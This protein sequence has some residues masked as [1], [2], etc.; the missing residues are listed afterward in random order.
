MRKVS[1]LVVKVSAHC[2]ETASSDLLPKRFFELMH[3]VFSGAK[4][5]L[6]NSYV[7]SSQGCG[8]LETSGNCKFVFFIA[9]KSHGKFC[10]EYVVVVVFFVCC[11]FNNVLL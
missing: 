2:Q 11:F 10:S 8:N 6:N 4:Q 9:W 5:A 3:N 7:Q 1:E